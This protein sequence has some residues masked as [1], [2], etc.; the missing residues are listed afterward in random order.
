MIQI[1]D[2]LVSLDV[3]ERYFLCDL[4]KCTVS[5]SKSK[6]TNSEFI[7]MIADKLRLAHKTALAN[8]G[9]YL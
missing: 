2:T 7:A 3:I 9:H 1:D 8:K 4:S 5:A 6:P